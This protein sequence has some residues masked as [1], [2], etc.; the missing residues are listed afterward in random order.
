MLRNNQI[1][2]IYF[3][4]T[5]AALIAFWQVYRCDFISYDD[6]TYVTENA[7]IRHGVTIDAVRWAFTTVYAS[8]WHPLTWVSH[9]IDIQLF[10]LKPKYHHLTN[11][12]F[13]IANTLFLFFVFHRMTK[14]PWKSAFA[15]ALFAVH[16]LHVESVAWV[17]ER[18]DVLS[19]FFWML[20]MA[21]YIHYA[22][23][24]RIR[25]Y[26]A[27]PIFFAL[28][29]MAKPMLVTLPFV[30][31]LLD[32]WPLGRLPAA[33][34]RAQEARNEKQ[35]TGSDKEKLS[36]DKKKGK[37]S[38]KVT[39]QGPTQSSAFGP[40]LLEKVPLFA[41]AAFSCILTYAAQKIGG[42]VVSFEQF[43]PGVRIANGI[44]SYI[45][46]IR[47]SIWPYDLAVFYPHPGSIP[48]WQV[49]GAAVLLAAI[50]FIL[51]S[52]AKRFPYLA[53]GWLWF[54]GTLIPVIGIVQVGTQSMADRYTYVPSIGLFIMVSWGVPELFAKLRIPKPALF[55][56]SALVILCLVIVSGKQVG[57]W[58]N[59]IQLYNHALDVTG[60]N[61]IIL[62]NR[63][64][65]YA[66]LGDLRHAVSDYDIA[67]EANPRNFEVYYNRGIAFGKLG[68]H[69]Q[70][71]ND[72]DKCIEIN[73]EHAD[74]FFNRCVAHDKLGNF[75][76][77]IQDCDRAIEI[78]PAHFEAYL[79]RGVAYG[80]LGSH[81]LAIECFDKVI[82]I[83]PEDS[84]AYFNRG[85]AYSELGDRRHAIEDLKTA[86]RLG[87]EN[88]KSSL[89][90]VGT[91]W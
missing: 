59:S 11:L 13:H 77:A 25:S 84:R 32:Y 39:S 63:G 40:L 2:L 81:R 80:E 8:N 48:L 45:V 75:R 20:T 58:N 1:R 38:K 27:V 29:L 85:V 67:V 21:A 14:A 56:S 7:H 66:Q 31:L 91:S 68:D 90:S 43:S 30:L 73:P 33:G 70:A 60:N 3:L 69:R 71:I 54:A 50:T 87:D 28:G 34:S 19:T 53:F 4:L 12:L 51:I 36:A 82:E 37:A 62:N 10:A 15:A 52:E 47:K 88:A 5:T 57:Y 18:K 83:N 78:D 24:P 61:D 23:N 22:E 79:N 35:N 89:R 17:A 6:P 26:L 42:S 46:Y 65:A 44:V 72:F 76:Q 86:A 49:A 41:L 64:V 55:V 16:P 74:A 9:M